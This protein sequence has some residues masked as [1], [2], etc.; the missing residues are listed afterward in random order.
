VRKNATEE[1]SSMRG[2][3]V[4][5]ICSSED[6]RE[7]ISLGDSPI[8]NSLLKA[9]SQVE[10]QFYPLTLK[11]CTECDLGQIG[12]FESPEDIFSEYPYLSST[13]SFWLN[14]AKKFALEVTDD[15]NL[16]QD[17]LV[18]EIAS[19]DGYLLKEFKKLNVEVLGIEP[20][21]NIARIANSSGIRTEPIFFGRDSAKMI[22]AQANHPKLIVANNVAAH[23]PDLNDFFAGLSILAGPQSF[24]SIENPSLG[25]LLE[26]GYFDT[27]Y[28]EHF[29]Y[30]SVK[31]IQKIASLHNLELIKV[32]EVDTHGG[33][34]RYWIRQAGIQQPEDSV[35]QLLEKES[36]RGVGS[37]AQERIFAQNC[38]KAML[39]LAEWVNLQDNNSIIGYGAAAKTVTIFFAASLNPEKFMHIIDGSSFKQGNRLPGTCIKV[40]DPKNQKSRKG[41]FLV[42]PW[43]LETEIKEIILLAHEDPE[44]WVSNPL[45]RIH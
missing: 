18:I 21:Q 16:N 33:S 34:L 12:E 8:A 9:H 7:I 37:L 39:D 35:N 30:L 38:R 36:A 11:I 10:E 44:I 17:D 28:H 22:L 6:L 3:S 41:K 2:N 45:R 15:L 29:S 40:V 31:S 25:N 19:N 43:N 24:V 27:V 13:S 23:V 1:N 5:R 32:E 14:H 20:A 4:C 42:F 26:K